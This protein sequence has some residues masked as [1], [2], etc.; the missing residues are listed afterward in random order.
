MEMEMEM[1][2]DIINSRL[3][4]NKKPMSGFYFFCFYCIIE[5]WLN[6]GIVFRLRRQLR[7]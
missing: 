7:N 2:M 6:C 5:A 3:L 4:V 1:E